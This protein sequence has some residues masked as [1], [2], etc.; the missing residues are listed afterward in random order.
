MLNIFR[1]ENQRFLMN[2]TVHWDGFKIS[3]AQIS[4]SVFKVIGS[5]KRLPRP[6]QYFP[7]PD[8]TLG[9]YSATHMDFKPALVSFVIATV[10]M[11]THAAE[12]CNVAVT[13][14]HRSTT[15]I[16][17]ATSAMIPILT[18][19]L[20]KCLALV[21]ISVLRPITKTGVRQPLRLHSSMAPYALQR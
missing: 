7:V 13:G 6:P 5:G 16:T 14:E 1:S 11:V 3:T 17:A 15:R 9:S 2:F 20:S 10:A 18:G 8:G 4:R 21:R 19:M 12:K